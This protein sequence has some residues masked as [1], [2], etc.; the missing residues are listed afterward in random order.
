MRGSRVTTDDHSTTTT[1]RLL[2]YDSGVAA[3]SNTIMCA[4]LGSNECQSSSRNAE[5]TI[6]EN[7]ISL[8][9]RTVHDPHE[10]VATPHKTSCAVT[11][12]CLLFRDLES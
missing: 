11:I 3:C 12:A 10:Y 9:L 5:I 6:L 7:G 1:A 8:E 2:D 4:T